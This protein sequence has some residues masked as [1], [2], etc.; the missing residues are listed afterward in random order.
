MDIYKFHV[1]FFKSINLLAPNDVH[2]WFQVN[3]AR[4]GYRTRLDLNVNDGTIIRNLFVPSARTTNYGL[5]QL[6]VNV[7]YKI[8]HQIKL[9]MLLPHIYL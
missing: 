5:K 4:H 6:R 3:H 7:G 1:L 9:K 8:L 2:G